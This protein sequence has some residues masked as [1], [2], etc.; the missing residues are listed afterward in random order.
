M[1]TVT[2]KIGDNLF[3]IGVGVDYEQPISEE[4]AVYGRLGYMHQRA[5]ATESDYSEARNAVEAEL[6]VRMYLNF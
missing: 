2:Y 3:S 6:G 1:G 4:A 5:S